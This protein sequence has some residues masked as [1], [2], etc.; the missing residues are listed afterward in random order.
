MRDLEDGITS[1]LVFYDF[2]IFTL[3]RKALTSKEDPFCMAFLKE[4]SNPKTCGVLLFCH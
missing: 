4:S 3:K 1:K 2:M